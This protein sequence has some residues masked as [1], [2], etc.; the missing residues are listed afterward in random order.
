MPRK[1]PSSEA[2]NIRQKP[3]CWSRPRMYRPGTVK[4]APAT[5]RPEAEPMDWIITFCCSAF[6]FFRALLRPIARI[7]I[8]IAASKTWPIFRPR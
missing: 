4:M 1:P 5:T 8:G 2:M 3:A 6:F 7:V